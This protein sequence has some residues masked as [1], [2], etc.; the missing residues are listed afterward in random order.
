M[1]NLAFHIEVLNRVISDPGFAM[2]PRRQKVIDNKKFAVLGALGPDLLRYTPVSATLAAHLVTLAQNP[3]LMNP[4]A[5][6]PTNPN[7]TEALVLSTL[8]LTGLLELQANPLGA[9]YSVVFSMLVVPLWP[10][11]NQIQ[12]FLSGLSAVV[13]AQNQLGLIPFATQISGIIS[14]ANSLSNNASVI[15]QLRTIVGVI[16]TLPPWMEQSTIPISQPSDP[17]KDRLFEFLRWHS[18]G[19]FASTLLNTASSDQ[20][21]AYA[22]G[23]LVHVAASVTAEPF[24]NNITGGPYRTH[25]WRN[26]LVSNFVDSWTFGFFEQPGATMSGDNPTPAYAAWPALCEANLQEEF[27]IAGFMEPTG[28]DVPDALKNMATGNLGTLP[29]QVPASLAQYFLNAVNAVYPAASQ[30]NGFSTAAFQNSVVGAFAVFWFMTSGSGPLGINAI[31]APP[32]T[33]TTAPSWI[34]S[35]TPP[36]P[37]QLGLNTPGAVCASLLAILALLELLFGDLPGGLATLAAAINAPIIN[38]PTVSCNL[39][40]ITKSLVDAENALQSALVQG[41]LA[42]PPPASLGTVAPDAS[43]VLQTTPAVDQSR[44]PV[45]FT[46]T[47]TL[48]GLGIPNSD[49]LYPRQMDTSNMAADLDFSSYPNSPNTHA[50]D[51]TTMNF[52]A[53]DVYPNVV[54]N[55]SGLQ[56]GGLMTDGAFPSR[57]Q[58]FGDAVSNALDLLHRGPGTLPSYNL[59]GDRG[60]GWKT[61]N[62]QPGSDPDTPPVVVVQE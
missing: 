62:P 16:L 37:Q 26:R 8:G 39:F 42:Y 17:T 45:P 56:N 55:G 38:W 5:P 52:P 35:G 23:Y 46:K 48:S 53:A 61:W 13:Q 36:S 60:Y 49:S 3:A 43:N 14:E 32:S 15:L 25:W 1:P 21:L 18:T 27:N 10:T 31:G 22:I 30:P 59:D 24:V 33:C 29:S 6:T 50:E 40:W 51:P 58:F 54:V 28:G 2:D 11:V 57:N 19:E 7:P 12:T 44:V 20:E 4:P 41:G 47:N 34:T 9:I